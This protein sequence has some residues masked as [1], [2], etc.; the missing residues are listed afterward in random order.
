MP[1]AT[2]GTFI[3]Q[4]GSLANGRCAAVMLISTC[5]KVLRLR[6]AAFERARLIQS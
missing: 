4:D 6:L 1:D 2:I 3:S 5:A